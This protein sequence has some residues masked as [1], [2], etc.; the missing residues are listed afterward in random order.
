MEHV[1]GLH[2]FSAAD[3]LDRLSYYCLDRESRTTTSVTVH[4]GE[5]DAVEVKSVIECLGCLHCILTCHC[6]HDKEGL[7]R[8]E[9]GLECRDLVHQFLV[10]SQTSGCVD[11]NYRISF[12]LCLFYCIASDLNRILYPF[13]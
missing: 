11:D 8:V 7:C 10:Y 13:F 9:S 4:L 6:I 3:E 5:D 1:E 2:L 12:C